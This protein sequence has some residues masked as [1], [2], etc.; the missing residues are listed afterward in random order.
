MERC[1]PSKPS[2]A[3]VSHPTLFMQSTISK[4]DTLGAAV[5]EQILLRSIPPAGLPPPMPVFRGP[6]SIRPPIPPPGIDFRGPPPPI[7]PPKS[8]SGKDDESWGLEPQK[9]VARQDREQFHL[10]QA[11]KDSLD[12]QNEAEHSTHGSGDWRKS[13]QA[14]RKDGPFVTDGTGQAQLQGRVAPSW[15]DERAT[16]L[17]GRPNI[18]FALS[19]LADEYLNI[20]ILDEDRTSSQY[21]AFLLD[22]IHNLQARLEFQKRNMKPLP[23]QKEE[24]TETIALDKGPRFLVLHRVFCGTSH[25]D[26]DATVYEDVP[27]LMDQDSGAPLGEEMLCGKVIIRDVEAYLRKQKNVHFVVYK[28]YRCG[29][30]SSWGAR[31]RRHT[32]QLLTDPFKM[33]RSDISPRQE[34]MKIVSPTLQRALNGVAT[35]KLDQITFDDP[36]EDS[37]ELQAPYM[38]LFHHRRQLQEVVQENQVHGPSVKLLLEYLNANFGQEY[39][40]AEAMIARGLVAENN[41]D[42]LFKPNQIVVTQEKGIYNAYMLDEWPV[43]KSNQLIFSGWQ[44]SYNGRNLERNVWRHIL[45][46]NFLDEKQIKKL[47]VQPIEHVEE[48][49]IIRLRERGNQFWSMKRQRLVSYDGWDHHHSYFYSRERFMVDMATYAKIHGSQHRPKIGGP[50]QFDSMPDMISQD[51]N[52]TDDQSLLLPPTMHG[53]SLREKKWVSINIDQTSEVVWNKQAFKRLVLDSETKDLISALIDVR[54]SDSKKMDD[55]V[56]GKGNGLIMLL[57]GSPGTG[58]TLTAE[59]VA[60]FAEKPLYRVTCGD[61]GT[62]AT[63]VEKYLE[64]V[65]YLAKIWDCVLLLDEADVFLEERSVSDLQ[66]NSLVSVFLRV[67]EYYEGIMILTSNRVGTFDEAFQSRIRVALR[68]EPLT[69]K[70]RKAIWRNFF[71]MLDDDDDDIKVNIRGL[72]DRLE[73]LAAYKMNGRQIRNVVL[74]AR[75]LA[76][77]RQESLEWKHLSQVLILSDNFSKY[78]K[79]IRGVSDETWAK[80]QSLR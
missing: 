18:T 75:Q 67:L 69:F 50:D 24:Q 77:H 70:S 44:W 23:P 41:I 68:Y 15:T 14:Q 78:L 29:H 76:L 25:H 74:T 65:L 53:Y 4:D 62:V 46:L 5:K 22:V 56:V 37:E 36:C 40:D 7:R 11:V 49:V 48:D 52:L 72:D 26:H 34:R 39:I 45:D 60:E 35:C 63:T 61:M 43:K 55:L 58:K 2:L 51:D 30:G 79:D 19:S 71:D 6:P 32:D 66:R 27:T 28:E 16:T 3:A 80:S 1:G 17:A 54:M 64:T 8:P 57:H 47:N 20:D 73:E 13:L 42:K 33:T 9:K 10:S 59:S 12:T 31:Q 21:M 38:F